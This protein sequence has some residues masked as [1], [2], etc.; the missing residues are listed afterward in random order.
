M[1]CNLP[2]KKKMSKGNERLVQNLIGEY[3]ASKTASAS[4]KNYIMQNSWD[5]DDYKT[6]LRHY[7]ET[8][9]L[10]EKLFP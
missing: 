6:K 4:I 9:E 10:P 7:E 8:G 5:E 3:F 1:K 2:G